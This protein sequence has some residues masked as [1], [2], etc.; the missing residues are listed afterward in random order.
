M[1]E[2]LALALPLTRPLPL[3]DAVAAMLCI[4][5]AVLMHLEVQEVLV[6]HGR[7]TSGALFVRQLLGANLAALLRSAPKVALAWQPLDANVDPEEAP[8]V[9]E[10]PEEAAEESLS[11]RSWRPNALSVRA[12]VLGVGLSVLCLSARPLLQLC[13]LEAPSVQLLLYL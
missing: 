4:P 8:V 1:P 6:E 12:E 3:A 5:L 2:A 10:A 7:G 11:A 13:A 9:P